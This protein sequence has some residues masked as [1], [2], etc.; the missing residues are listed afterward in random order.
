MRRP[1]PQPSAASAVVLTVDDWA[2]TF[3]VP[4]G[5]ERQFEPGPRWL[6][7]TAGALGLVLAV[8]LL[9]PGPPSPLA[10][11]GVP[12]FVAC[13]VAIALNLGGARGVTAATA[14]ATLAWVAT[15]AVLLGGAFPDHRLLIALLTLGILGHVV[16]AERLRRRAHEDHDCVVAAR[17]GTRTDGWVVHVDGPPWERHLGVEAS[18]GTGGP[19]TGSQAGWRTL[20]PGVG[21]PVGIWQGEAGR[22]VVLLPRAPR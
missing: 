18:G 2:G 4:S 1:G 11:L 13:A 17:R 7:P 21:H 14:L 16:G 5:A 8:L 20:R 6:V 15:G 22:T 3:Q 10:W 12:L 19:W 9:S